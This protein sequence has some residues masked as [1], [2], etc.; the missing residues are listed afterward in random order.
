[1]ATTAVFDRDNRGKMILTV[2]FTAANDA[3]VFQPLRPLAMSIQSLG[4]FTA[5]TLDIQASNDG[6]TYYALPT[7]KSLSALG[8]LSVAAIDLGFAFYRVI[9]LS[10]SEAHTAVINWNEQV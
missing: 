1:M 4:A 2:T 6:V 5:A 3:V 9:M 10:A 8:V 7:A